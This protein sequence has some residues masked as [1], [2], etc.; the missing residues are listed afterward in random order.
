MSLIMMN[1]LTKF[2]L[3]LKILEMWSDKVSKILICKMLDLP[4]K[5]FSFLL[6]LAKPVY[7]FCSLYKHVNFCILQ[8][9]LCYN[10]SH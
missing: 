4:L 7:C 2:Y 5:T 8:F 10:S 3:Q 1:S 9:Y 6:Y